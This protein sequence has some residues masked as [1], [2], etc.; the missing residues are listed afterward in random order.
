MRLLKR[1]GVGFAFKIANATSFTTPYAIL[2]HTSGN[3]EVTRQQLLTAQ[4][5]GGMTGRSYRKIMFTLEQAERD[6]LK[7]VWVDTCCIDK[8]TSV[9]LSESISLI[10]KWYANA[11]VCYAYLNGPIKGNRWFTR[12]WTLQ[13]LV[14]PK[15][16]VHFVIKRSRVQGS[17]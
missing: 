1:D 16:L 9:E 8:T 5:G 12:G 3:E 11:Q 14:A 2:P 10:W 6:G 13:E 4:N 7:Y 17:S 15:E